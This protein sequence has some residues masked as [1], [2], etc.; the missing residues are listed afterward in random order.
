MPGLADQLN[1]RMH[2]LVY[3]EAYIRH[4]GLKR[5]VNDVVDQHAD[6]E[7]VIT[8]LEE[9]TSDIHRSFAAELKEIFSRVL[10]AR[11]DAVRE[12]LGIRH[13]ELYATLVDMHEVPGAGE[14]LQ[15]FLTLNYDV[16]LEDAIK[17]RLGFHVDYG[18]D[19]AP[20]PSA[21]RSVRVLKLHGSFGW[22]NEWPIR[23]TDEHDAGLWIPPGIRKAKGDYPF[24]AIWGMAR[25]LLNCD[26][27]RI[28]GCNLGPND[29]DLVSLLFTTMHTHAS[30]GPYDIEVIA[31]PRTAERIADLF[32]YL[33]VRS[34]LEIPDIGEQII[35]E[36]M[37]TTPTR[38]DVLTEEEQQEVT[39]S[40]ESRIKNP[41]EYWL[42]VKGELLSRDLPSL[43][44]SSGL[45]ARFV[46]T[47]A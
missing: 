39:R 13:S 18:I 16:F 41:F 14:R 1:E 24:N 37:G 29:W 5:L 27:V 42:R 47:Q 15:G 19:V 45:F 32:P 4:A 33:N 38:Y 40:A 12:E 23:A 2:E 6:F 26:V 22:E 8:F 25:E 30:S 44:T 36:I 46:E 3:Q 9:A 17:S 20:G 43:G 10:R 11:L 21:E 31:P 7:Q 28:I 35:G 34:L